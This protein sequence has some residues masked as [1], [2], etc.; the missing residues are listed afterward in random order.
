MFLKES[1]EYVRKHYVKTGKM[2]EDELKEVQSITKGDAFSPLIAQL[3]I[4]QGS[5]DSS[6]EECEDMYRL[7]RLYVQ[8]KNFL[9][10]SELDNP[11]RVKDVNEVYSTLKTR[12]LLISIL[13]N[14][15]SNIQ[16]NLRTVLKN[17][18]QFSTDSDNYTFNVL[19][20]SLNDILE[21]WNIIKRELRKTSDLDS[22]AR[23]VFSS[24]F[25]NFGELE[26]ILKEIKISLESG[27]F[28]ND[29]DLDEGLKKVEGQYAVLWREGNNLL[30]KVETAKAMRVLGC[31]TSWC[32]SQVDGKYWWPRYRNSD[33]S[34]LLLMLNGQPAYVFHSNVGIADSN[35]SNLPFDSTRVKNLLS[36]L[37]HK[38]GE[39]AMTYL[40]DN[41]WNPKY[42]HYKDE[43]TDIYDEDDDDDNDSNHDDVDDTWLYDA[44]PLKVNVNDLQLILKHLFHF[45][46]NKGALNQFLEKWQNMN[47]KYKPYNI[48]D[49]V[50]NN[51]NGEDTPYIQKYYSNVKFTLLSYKNL[52]DDF[53]QININE[54]TPQEQRNLFSDFSRM[55][56]PPSENPNQLKLNLEGLRLK[57]Y[58][59][60]SIFG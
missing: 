40:G 9:P 32:F 14:F 6:L 34:V 54:Y 26:S 52:L 59:L 5:D 30:L 8:S 53:F 46:V 20:H 57:N 44:L 35:N 13:D 12:N 39:D 50:K 41:G 21:Q 19:A 56:H 51:L 38:L 43:D 29:Y 42:G 25:T 16:R 18:L 23:R 60:K 3:F 55:I 47:V 27:S 22:I 49:Y 28:Y 11:N 48:D 33:G 15:D 24:N 37:T 2:T 10:I 17:E 4:E 36:Y 31:T 7:L 1:I 58:I 45:N